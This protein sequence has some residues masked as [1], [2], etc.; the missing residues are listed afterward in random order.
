LTEE[1]P[2][3]TTTHQDYF[4]NYKNAY[5]GQGDFLVKIPET[6]RV[7]A[8]MEAVRTSAKTGESV[9]FEWD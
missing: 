8:L 5:N 3:A 6:K 4:E 9:R 2:V 7:L 1:L